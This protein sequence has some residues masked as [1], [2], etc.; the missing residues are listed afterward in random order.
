MFVGPMLAQIE[1]LNSCSPISNESPLTGGP[2]D[3]G[4][5]TLELQENCETAFDVYV[6][7]KIEGVGEDTV[8]YDL[9][10]GD[11]MVGTIDA[12][13][14]G[15]DT[16]TGFVRFDP[17]PVGSEQE[18]KFPVGI[19]SLVRVFNAGAIPTEDPLV[20]SGEIVE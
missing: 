16:V 9:Y 4:T 17:T 7:V 20:L 10:V 3:S 6:E 5:A 1:G 12:T 15:A 11:D 13:G 2:D 19:G 18:L 14:D 8:V